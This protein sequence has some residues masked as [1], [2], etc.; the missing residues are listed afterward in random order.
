VVMGER[1]VDQWEPPA[2][3]EV[4]RCGLVSEAQGRFYTKGL[5]GTGSRTRI[6]GS[7]SIGENSLVRL[8]PSASVERARVVG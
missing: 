1:T 3:H 2:S 7:N 5:R 4:T 6:L 8:T